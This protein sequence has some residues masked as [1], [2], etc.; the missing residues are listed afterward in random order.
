[1]FLKVWLGEQPE[2][3]NTEFIMAINKHEKKILLSEI[4]PYYGKRILK[5]HEIE[6][7]ELDNAKIKNR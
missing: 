6:I 2:L 7:G 1:M 3:I 5:Y 4:L